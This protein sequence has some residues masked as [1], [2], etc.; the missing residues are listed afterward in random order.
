MGNQ[1]DVMF[2]VDYDPNDPG[3]SFI[4]LYSCLLP[5]HLQANVALC[6]F[7]ACNTITCTT[8]SPFVN[9]HN[10]EGL[11]WSTCMLFSTDEPL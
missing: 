6:Y 4:T 7:E 5:L 2:V 8:T 11:S 10:N 9:G 3:S 1:G